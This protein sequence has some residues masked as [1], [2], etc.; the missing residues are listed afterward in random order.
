MKYKLLNLNSI[1]E[2]GTVN[3]T[4]IQD[5]IGTLETAKRVAEETMAANSYKIYVVVCEE[6]QM[7]LLSGLKYYVHLAKE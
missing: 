6:T 5:H 1:N 3:G 2:D 7:D 4:W